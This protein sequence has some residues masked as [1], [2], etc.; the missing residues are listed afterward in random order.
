[1][2]AVL[3]GTYWDVPSR[4]P[5]RGDSVPLMSS[6]Q[7][8]TPSMGVGSENPTPPFPGGPRRIISRKLEAYANKYLKA[9]YPLKKN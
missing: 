8:L 3:S 1:M 9:V 2:L 5:S 4:D 7:S 6:M